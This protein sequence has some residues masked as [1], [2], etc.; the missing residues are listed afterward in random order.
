LCSWQQQIGTWEG[1]KDDAQQWMRI[2]STEHREEEGEGLETISNSLN[3]PI[4][5]FKLNSTKQYNLQCKTI[6]KVF[7]VTI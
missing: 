5:I 6:L 7:L 4:P 1:V 3:I 2:R